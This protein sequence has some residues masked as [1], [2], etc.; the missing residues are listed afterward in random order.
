M[1][2]ELISMVSILQDLEM[3]P[4]KPAAETGEAQVFKITANDLERL[5]EYLTVV[6]KRLPEFELCPAAELKALRSGAAVMRNALY[7][8]EQV[9]QKTLKESGA[10]AQVWIDGTAHS[11]PLARLI[12][13][14]MSRI[15]AIS[16]K[17]LAE[18]DAHAIMRH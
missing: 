5:S 13:D 3:R 18:A 11:G 4:L 17:A 9:I 10:D 7:G 2:S 8:F 16:Q 12:V 14:V 6:A 1:K 15:R